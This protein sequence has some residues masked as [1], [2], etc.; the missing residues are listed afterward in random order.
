MA[1]SV[2]HTQAVDLPIDTPTSPPARKLARRGV[3]VLVVNTVI[4]LFVTLM[5]GGLFWG[6][7]LYSQ[8]I[9]L[10]I[11]SFIELG[12]RFFL[13]EESPGPLKWLLVTLGAVLAGYLL[14]SQLANAI[15]GYSLLGFWQFEPR[16]AGAM[17]LL[18]LVAGG[19]VTYY[20]ASRSSIARTRAQAEA[21]QRQAAEARLK[22]L[23]TQLEPHML[24]NTLANL[25]VLIATDPARAQQMLDR[26][27]AYLRATLGASRAS[28]HPLHEEFERLRDYLELMAVRMG[29][30]LAYT[31]DLPPWLDRHPVP[32]LLLQPLVENAIRHGLE[33]KVEGGTLAVRAQHDGAWLTLEVTDTGVGLPAGPD[34]APDAAPDDAPATGFGLAQVRE[35]LATAYGSQFTMELIAPHAGGTRTIIRFPYQP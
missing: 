10:C 6:N 23:Q 30:R 13:A 7:L 31:L 26:L 18:S 21:A 25:R 35:R 1:P 8:A 24:F 5:A 32:T 34:R 28:T 33:P 11:W 16:K 14:G 17:L 9:G 12:Q 27:I 29:P 3:G 4:A 19:V 2:V 20:F 15:T 22:L